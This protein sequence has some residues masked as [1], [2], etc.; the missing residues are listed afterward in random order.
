LE[1]STTRN[2]VGL[3]AF[4]SFFISLSYLLHL[5]HPHWRAAGT[6]GFAILLPFKSLSV[7]SVR[8]AH[9]LLIRPR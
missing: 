7:A 1:L 4:L 8:C 6:S 5:L 2:L 9:S 3:R